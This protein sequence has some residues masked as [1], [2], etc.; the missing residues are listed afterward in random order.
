MAEILSYPSP[1]HNYSQ[2]RRTHN[3]EHRY[4][5]KFFGIPFYISR[6][7]RTDVQ[8]LFHIPIIG[9]SCIAKILDIKRIKALG[10]SFISNVFWAIAQNAKFLF[11]GKENHLKYQKILKETLKVALFVL[12]NKFQEI[13]NYGISFQPEKFLFVR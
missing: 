11:V 9:N 3:P 5:Q 12:K 1:N 8:E 6:V 13:E 10:F 2:L 7:I 4:L